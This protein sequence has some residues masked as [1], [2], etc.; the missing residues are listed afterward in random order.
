[1]ILKLKVNFLSNISH[2]LTV[3]KFLSFIDFEVQYLIMICRGKKYEP[4]NNQKR[5]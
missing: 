2:F 5:S 3:F 4:K 1:M